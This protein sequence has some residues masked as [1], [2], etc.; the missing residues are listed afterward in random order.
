MLFV[1]V[2]FF[3]ENVVLPLLATLGK[4]RWLGAEEPTTLPNV[5]EFFHYSCIGG[6][7]QA[8]SGVERTRFVQR[9]P[10]NLIRTYGCICGFLTKFVRVCLWWLVESGLIGVHTCLFLFFGA[11]RIGWL[12]TCLCVPAREFIGTL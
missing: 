1:P 8:V 10:I 6:V 9:S 2:T 4:Y 12:K 5:C 11:H 3:L 7:S